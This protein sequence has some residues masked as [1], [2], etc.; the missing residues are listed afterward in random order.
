MAPLQRHERE[1]AGVGS[2]LSVCPS[3]V[4][5]APVE[6]VWELLTRPEG[7]DLWVD[8]VVVAAEPEGPVRPGSR[9]HLVTRALGWRFAVTIEVREVDAERRRLRFLVE[10]PFGMMNDEVVTMADSGDGGTLVRFG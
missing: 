2:T 10:L 4:V 7:F 8:A 3:A 1:N 6:R 5:E 9:L